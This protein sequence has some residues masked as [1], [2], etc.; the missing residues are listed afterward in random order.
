[1]AI[2]VSK[3]AA[4]PIGRPCWRWQV[5]FTAEER[6]EIGFDGFL[7]DL[8][9][10]GRGSDAMDGLESMEGAAASAGALR[11]SL[12]LEEALAYLREEQ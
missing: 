11:Q 5:L 12:G 8:A 4:Y 6:D 2:A 10:S 1:M 7:S 9:A 3:S